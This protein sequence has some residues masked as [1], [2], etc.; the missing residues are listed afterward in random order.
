M[1][2]SIGVLMGALAGFALLFLTLA[3]FITKLRD[4]Q[5]A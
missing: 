2:L 4:K 1:G 5:G 3:T